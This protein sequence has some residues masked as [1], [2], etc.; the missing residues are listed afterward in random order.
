MTA[1]TKS[2][3]ILFTRH[4][5]FLVRSCHLWLGLS[6]GLSPYGSP[7]NHSKGL[8]CL[9]FTPPPPVYCIPLGSKQNIEKTRV[10]AVQQFAPD[11]AES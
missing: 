4:A 8:L 3:L 9:P 5:L 10:A 7:S 6:N 2:T 1:C 11:V